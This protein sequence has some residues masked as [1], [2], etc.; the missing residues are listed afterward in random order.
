MGNGT[1]ALVAGAGVV[2]F[3]VVARQRRHDDAGGVVAVTVLG[4]PEDVVGAWEVDGPPAPQELAV[5]P[6]PADRGTE[7]RVRGSDGGGLVERVR[8]ES[9]RQQVRD[10]LRRLKS[11]LEA[12][13]VITTEGQPSGRGPVAENLTEA[14]SRRLRAW[15][16]P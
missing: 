10:R 7:I 16:A 2:G 6:A 5:A 15:G 14:V 4:L 8:G 11:T 12:G 13:E 1:K 3:A 9:P